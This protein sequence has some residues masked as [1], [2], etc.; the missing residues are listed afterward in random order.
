MDLEPSAVR[1]SSEFAKCAKC[2]KWFPRVEQL[3]CQTG[4]SNGF[5][6]STAECSNEIRFECDQLRENLWLCL[7]Y[8]ILYLFFALNYLSHSKFW[9][10]HNDKATNWRQLDR[11]RLFH[12]IPWQSPL[13]LYAYNTFKFIFESKNSL[14]FV[15]VIAILEFTVSYREN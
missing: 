6:R 14:S 9:R 10:F 11:F 4:Q 13:V 5:I 15:Q 8:V 12:N 7:S 2:A 1:P 3:T